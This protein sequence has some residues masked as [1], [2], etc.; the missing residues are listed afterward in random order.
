MRLSDRIGRQMKLHD[1]HVLMAVAQTGSMGRAAALLST[2]QPA[3][4]KSIAQLERA[5]GVPLL[6]RSPKGVEPTPYGRALLKRGTVAFDELKQ[7]VRDIEYLSE[8]GTGELLIGT[9]PSLSEGVVFATIDRLSRQHPRLS[10]Q[11]ALGGTIALFDDLRARRIDLGFVRLTGHTP[12]EDID[13][14]VLFEDS[15]VVIASANSSLARRRKIKLADLVDEP[16]TW[17]S[18]GTMLDSIV[19]DAFRRGG[20][21]PPRA[22]IYA[23]S[24]NLKIKLAATG[25]F[26]A[27]VP[28]SVLR[29]AAT[30]GLIKV[31][32][33]ALPTTY[34]PSG[35]IT[36]KNRTLSSPAQLFVRYAREIARP[37]A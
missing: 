16:W 37:L 33:V 14:E 8:P 23:E 10:I 18:P 13:Q 25:R 4:S 22:A 3:I 2:T 30:D 24:I 26:L 12:P 9:S 19:I 27:I 11:I 6:E 15:L 5:I 17:S 1:L 7:G 34:Q 35:F 28:A 20:L 36:L 21:K 31:L 29:Y 32:P